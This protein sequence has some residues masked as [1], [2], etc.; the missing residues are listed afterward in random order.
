M[1][2]FTPGIFKQ[3]WEGKTAV[4]VGAK[5][6]A[7]SNEKD[8]IV[9]IS[10]RCVPHPIQRNLKLTQFQDVLKKHEPISINDECFNF[11]NG[12]LLSEKMSKV[13]VTGMYVKRKT[14]Y[15]LS[16]TTTL[17]I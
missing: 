11:V 17:D 5:V 9:K 3:E 13:A 2:V 1:S 14:N 10:C 15:D 6:Y 7:V 4:G 8:E 16:Y 12:H